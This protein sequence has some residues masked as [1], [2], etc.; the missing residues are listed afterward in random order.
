MIKKWPKT[1]LH[2]TA[3]SSY[4]S[5]MTACT[6]IFSIV[7]EIGTPYNLETSTSYKKAGQVR[8]ARLFLVVVFK[9]DFKL[10][11]WDHEL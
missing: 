4:T 9:Y 8:D 3:G 10:S 6:K 7:P 1:S 5:K 11:L 2:L